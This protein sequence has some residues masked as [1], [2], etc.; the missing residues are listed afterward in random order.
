MCSPKPA[1][2]T[3]PKQSTTPTSMA[4]PDAE[5]RSALRRS[6][7]RPRPERPHAGARR[8]R[9]GRRAATDAECRS[10]PLM[11]RSSDASDVDSAVACDRSRTA[12]VTRAASVARPDETHFAL[13]TATQGEGRQTRAPRPL[14]RAPAPDDPAR[15][16][17]ALGSERAGYLSLGATFLNG[18][19]GCSAFSAGSP[20]PLQRTRPPSRGVVAGRRTYPSDRASS[21]GVLHEPPNTT[22][23][24][25]R[26]KYG[27]R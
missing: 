21:R 14:A 19:P 15:S 12:A 22:A 18:T 25:Q 2:A 1:R 9:S 11:V 5:H 23:R 20:D 7:F 26:E 24:H 6:S 4:S 8:A 3:A 10:L 16:R 13:G 17:P 27:L